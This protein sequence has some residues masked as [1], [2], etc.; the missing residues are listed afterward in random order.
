MTDKERIEKLERRITELEAEIA[1]IKRFG[2]PPGIGK[3]ITKDIYSNC[4][5]TLKK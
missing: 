5:C 4:L 1:R 3:P 2:S